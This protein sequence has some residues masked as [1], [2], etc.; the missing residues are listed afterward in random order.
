MFLPPFGATSTPTGSP[1]PSNP[2]APLINEIDVFPGFSP[3]RAVSGPSWI[4]P[5][6]R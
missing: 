5:D 3:T 4:G 2:A 1:S 6:T